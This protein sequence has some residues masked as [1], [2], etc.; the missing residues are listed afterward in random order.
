MA[1]ANLSIWLNSLAIDRA[2]KLFNAAYAN[3][4]PH[5]GSQ[6]NAAALAA[7]MEPGDTLVWNGYIFS[8]RSLDSR[9]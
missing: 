2:K 1:D 6:A 4:Q 3:V 9:S 8:R 5:A 7:M